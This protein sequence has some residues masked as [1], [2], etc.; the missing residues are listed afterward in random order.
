MLATPKSSLSTVTLT[1]TADIQHDTYL[2]Q[3]LDHPDAASVLRWHGLR[4]VECLSRLT[5]ASVSDLYNLDLP[6]LLRDLR[7]AV[8]V[9]VEGGTPLRRS[10]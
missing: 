2:W 3:V 7:A 4:D 10:A 5:L 6:L 9:P 8:D 1:S